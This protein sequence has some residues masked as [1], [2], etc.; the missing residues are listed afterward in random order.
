MIRNSLAAGDLNAYTSYYSSA[1]Y[2]W[3]RLTTGANTTYQSISVGASPYWV[4]VARTGNSFT[5]YRSVDGV[6]WVQVGT[7]QTIEM[8][9]NIYIGL[10][11]S[12]DSNTTLTTATFDNVS[13]NT[14]PVAAPVITNLSATTGPVGSQVVISGTGFGVSQSSSVVTLHGSPVTI[15]SWSSISIAITIPTGATTGPLLVSVAPSM[16]DSNYVIFTVT[17]QPLPI[18]WLDQDVGTVGLAGS[19]TYANGVFTIQASGQGV[20]GL[21]ADQVHFVYQPLS[22]NATIVARVVSVAGGTYPLAGVMIRNSLAANDMNAY[23]SY[24]ST[25]VYFWERLT[26]GATTTYQAGSG[27][28]LP[29]WVKLVRNGSSFTSYKAPD[30]VNWVQISAVPIS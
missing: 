14:T 22:G 17:S 21:A 25:N 30:G 13:I 29:Y 23:T 7:A 15:N 4:A 3:N 24:Y 10:A 18:A 27:A 19:A 11:V 6:N 8:G 1:I 26:A 16:N 9:Q 28:T 12:S 2:F 5:S 20:Y